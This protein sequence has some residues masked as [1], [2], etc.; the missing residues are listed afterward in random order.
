[1]RRSLL[2][3]YVHGS[4]EAVE[5]YKRAFGAE[6]H[7]LYPDERG[8]YMHS[9]LTVYGQSFAVSELYGEARPGNTMQFCFELGEDRK[10]ELMTAYEALKDGAAVE[11]PPGVCDYSPCMFALTDRF[12][13]RWCVFL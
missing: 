12:G 8:G 3:V 4:V 10:D 7:A 1:M 6:V 2:Q 9:E 5:L 13:V 11:T